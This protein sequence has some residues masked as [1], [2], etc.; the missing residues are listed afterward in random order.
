M[1]RAGERPDDGQPSPE[2]DTSDDSIDSAGPVGQP[3]GVT[4]AALAAEVAELKAELE[5][6]REGSEERLTA[7]KRARADYENLKR[8]SAGE[9]DERVAQATSAL[10]LE[11]LPIVDNFERAFQA[12]RREDPDAWAAGLQLIEK[13]IVQFLE[14]LGV[15]PIAAEGQTFDPTYHEAVSQAPGAE[16][17]VVVQVRKGYLLGTR[18]LRPAMVVVGQGGEPGTASSESTSE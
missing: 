9:V 13:E 12:D 14:R 6:T 18:V 1:A 17:E 15:Q 11:L 7:W 10:L 2:S 5:R 4:L 8:R 3:S 16:N